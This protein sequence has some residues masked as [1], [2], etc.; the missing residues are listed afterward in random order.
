MRFKSRQ[1]IPDLAD[2]FR[3]FVDRPQHLGGFRERFDESRQTFRRAL[4]LTLI[5]AS[6]WIRSSLALVVFNVANTTATEVLGEII[7]T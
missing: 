6:R 3:H 2:D 1:Q 4:S 7:S 5:L